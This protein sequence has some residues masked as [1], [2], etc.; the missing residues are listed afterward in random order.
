MRYCNRV[1]INIISPGY[2]ILIP[3]LLLLL[4]LGCAGKSASKAMQV[5]N[6]DSKIIVMGKGNAQVENSNSNLP[7]IVTDRPVTFDIRIG[8]QSVTKLSPKL[9][10][11]AQDFT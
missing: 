1:V 9:S 10:P 7:T 11:D 8:N 6:D 3:S 5:D 4:I 2:G